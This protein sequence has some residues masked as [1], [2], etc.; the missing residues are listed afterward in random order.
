[1]VLWASVDDLVDPDHPYAET[2]LQMSSHI[3]Y[4]LTGEKFQ[5]VHTTTEFYGSDSDITSISPQLVG[6]KMYNL[7]SGRNSRSSVAMISGAS[8]K[9]YLRH[10]PIRKILEIREL[11]RVLQPTE[12]SIRNNS[13]IMKNGA[14]G[15]AFNSM[16]ELEV[17]Y[18]YGAVPPVAGVQAAIM[19]ANQLLLAEM[20]DENCALPVRVSSIQ[21]QNVNMTLLDPQEFLD[22][23]RTGLYSVDLFIRTYNPN[24]AKKKSKLF[25]AGRPRGERVT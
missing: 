24:G 10:Q 21:R 4:Q 13:F 14:S 2:A 6:G 3:L 5:G 23:G 20:G 9:L 15:W 19:F 12:Y 22:S 7:P 8:R 1:M 16:Q 18:E 11:G 25:V 17:T